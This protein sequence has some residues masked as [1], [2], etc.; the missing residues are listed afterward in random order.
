M[1]D[2][3]DGIIQSSDR[4]YHSPKYNTLLDSFENRIHSLT[5]AATI[6]NTLETPASTWEIGESPEIELYKLALLIYLERAARNVSGQSEKIYLYT[7]KAIKILSHMDSC[8]IPFPLFILGC[9]AQFDEHRAL[10]M[11]LVKSA[12]TAQSQ[13]LRQLESMLQA[14]WNQD[15]LQT[16]YGLDYSRKLGIVMT[17]NPVMPSFA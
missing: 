14:V 6:R 15:D 17:S 1:Y 9:E 11:R 13:A 7:S 5:S 8:E 2:V 16:D 10:I 4:L 12:R 3:F